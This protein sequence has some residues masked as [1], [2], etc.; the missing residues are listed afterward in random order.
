PSSSEC[1]PA[2]SRRWRS[3][4]PPTRRPVSRA[5]YSGFEAR[6]SSSSLSTG[7]SARSTMPTAGRRS[8]SARYSRGRWRTISRRWRRRASISATTLWYSARRVRAPAVASGLAL[9]LVG[10]AASTPG[11]LL[12]T[13]GD[14]EARRAVVWARAPSAGTITVTLS[15]PAEPERRVGGEVT[16]ERDFTLKLPVVGLSPGTRYG[17]RVDWRGAR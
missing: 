9:V 8:V 11:E 16:G 17:Y 2:T 14:V 15:A 12:V 4:W 1:R 10:G 7:P 5:R 3:I 6:R 13:V